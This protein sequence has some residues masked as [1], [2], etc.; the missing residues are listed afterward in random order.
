MYFNSSCNGGTC[1]WNCPREKNYSNSECDCICDN[2]A[3]IN[4]GNDDY[5]PDISGTCTNIKADDPDSTPE[6]QIKNNCIC[7]SNFCNTQQEQ[8]NKSYDPTNDNCNNCK[9]GA[10]Y[11]TPCKQ[12]NVDSNEEESDYCCA[13]G[14]DCVGDDKCYP[15]YMTFLTQNDDGTYTENVC[16]Q[17]TGV[18]VKNGVPTQTCSINFPD[19]CCIGDSDTCCREYCGIDGQDLSQHKLC[20][21]KGD[22][23]MIGIRTPDEES[24]DTA[25]VLCQRAE[26]CN[27]YEIEECNDG[28]FESAKHCTKCTDDSYEF[29]A[30]TG[31]GDIEKLN[32]PTGGR[33]CEKGLCIARL[34]DHRMNKEKGTNVTCNGTTLDPIPDGGYECGQCYT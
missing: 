3:L 23:C 5:L 32:I 12:K 13:N 17:N 26:Y 4:D 28:N 22:T 16:D 30:C 11:K 21:N 1:T 6:S 8:Q 19:T 14:I 25:D 33:K 27:K 34:K 10:D 18:S 15:P 20:S 29:A 24:P 31:E 7:T 9:V 2:Q